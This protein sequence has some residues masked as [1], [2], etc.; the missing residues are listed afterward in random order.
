MTIDSRV[1]PPV[2]GVWVGRAVVRESQLAIGYVRVPRQE[3]GA[4][5]F[6]VH[7]AIVGRKVEGTFVTIVRRRGDQSIAVRPEEMHA[8]LS[9][10]RNLL[11]GGPARAGRR[12]A[13]D[14]P[15]G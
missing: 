10:G 9:A 13:N 2:E 8:W 3:P 4:M 5:P 11:R 15:V 12:G 7:G 6:I 14:S 1:Y